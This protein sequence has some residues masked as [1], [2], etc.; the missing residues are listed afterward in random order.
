MLWFA[1]PKF[2]RCAAD[3]VQALLPFPSVLGAR[4][5]DSLITG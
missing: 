3:L 5:V 4:N 1:L 2:L